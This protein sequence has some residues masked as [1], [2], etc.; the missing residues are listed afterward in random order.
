MQPGVNSNHRGIKN[1]STKEKNSSGNNQ[2]GRKYL[3]KQETIL[4]IGLA[5]LDAMH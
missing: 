5:K 3:N 1:E 2:E 4:Q